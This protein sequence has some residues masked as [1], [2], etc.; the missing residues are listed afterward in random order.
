MSGRIRGFIDATYWWLVRRKNNA[1]EWIGYSSYPELK[2]FVYLDDTSLISLLSSTTGGITQQKTSS[3]KQRISAS[4]T[5]SLGSVSPSLKTSQENINQTVEKYVIQSSFKELYD[6]RKKDVAISDHVTEQPRTDVALLK[7]IDGRDLFTD[8]QPTT[9][10]VKRGDLFELDA[11]VESSDIYKYF[12][13]FGVF[14]DIVDSFSSEEEFR[15]QLQEEGVSTEEIALVIEMMDILMAGLVPVECSASSYGTWKENDQII[16]SKEWAEENDME[17]SELVISGFIDEEKLWADPSRILFSE[18][19]F[20]VYGRVDNPK[21]S[22][23]WSPL[24]LADIVSSVFPEIA[25]D[26]DDFPSVFEDSKEPEENSQRFRSGV[27]SYL[28]WLET[29][30]IENFPDGTIESILDEI[31]PEFSVVSFT[32]KHDLLQV[33]DEKLT[34]RLRIHTLNRLPEMRS[35]FLENQ[36]EEETNIRTQSQQ[37]EE[38]NEN[39]LEA[40]FVAIYW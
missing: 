13:V 10:T 29:E 27:E 39:Y 37:Q 20:T 30:N 15:H 11:T 1:L 36:W 4:I 31:S 32:D 22:S 2:E 40:N 28:H 35:E 12:Q 19:E 34:A 24:K 26:I 9:K 17:I 16:V 7:D 3:E 33:A 14:E 5:D 21:V 23:D 18:N 8:N 38:D 6:I 25:K